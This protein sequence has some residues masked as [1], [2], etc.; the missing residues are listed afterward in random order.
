MRID[1]LRWI[2]EFEVHRANVGPRRRRGQKR[3]DVLLAD[4][5]FDNGTVCS[6]SV[7]HRPT[8][9]VG[10]RRGLPRRAEARPSANSPRRGLNRCGWKRTRSSRLS[11]KAGSCARAFDS[12]SG[13]GRCG[14]DNR[15]NCLTRLHAI[16]PLQDGVGNVGWT[17]GRAGQIEDGAINA[18]Q[19]GLAIGAIHF[20]IRKS[21]R[22]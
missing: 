18:L 16:Q 20:L 21:D 8:L 15:R 13:D 6:A 14:G 9:R 3:E 5:P 7:P 4:G 10:A 17:F 1:F 19:H 2:E 12:D 11:T 22:L